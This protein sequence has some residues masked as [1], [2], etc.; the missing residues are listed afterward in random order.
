MTAVLAAASVTV[1]LL[2]VLVGISLL[3]LTAESSAEVMVV[4]PQ[5]Y[6]TAQIADQL[7]QNGIIRS[8]FMFQIWARLRGQATD[9]QAGKYMLS[10]ADAP[11]AIMDKLARG[12]VVREVVWITIPEGYTVEQMAYRFEEAGM[13]SQEEFVNTLAEI[14][15][16]FDW[17]AN[18]PDGVLQR[19]EGY[20]FPDTYEFEKGTS[21]DQVILRLAARFDAVVVPQ[22]LQSSLS[23]TYT[24][25]EIITMASMVEK[26]AAVSEE[27]PVIA[28]VFYNRLRQGMLLESCATVQYLLA[29][30]RPVLLFEDLEIDSP[31]NTYKYEGLPPGPIGNPGLG[32]IKAVLEPAETDYLY[33]VARGDGTHIFSRTFSE[34][35]AAIR[36]LKK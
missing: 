23:E 2:I 30:P 24:L 14:E 27:K 3:P 20:L 19:Y 6:T 31:Y 21:A 16:P 32:A 8:S 13:F 15:L 17:A 7:E 12:E 34:H 18:I 35:Q 5:G 29:E 1:C 28:G 36:S 11:F 9:F 10:P 33:F 26:E 22:Y 25:H 4:I